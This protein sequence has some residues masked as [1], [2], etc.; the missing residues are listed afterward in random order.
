MVPRLRTHAP[1]MLLGGVAGLYADALATNPVLTQSLTAAATFALS[2]QIA[3]AYDR[4][5][6]RDALRTI[7]SALIGLLY[8]GPALFHYLNFVSRL[9]PGTGLQSVLLKTLFGQLGFGPALSCVFFAAFLVKEDGVAR[10]LAQL[11]QKIKQ[12]LVMTW[13][14]ELCFW[15]FVD[16]LCYSFVPMAWIPLGYNVANFLWTIFLSLQAAKTIES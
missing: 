6:P 10:G 11:P 8:F 2:D 16:L 3:Q 13:A 1:S 4:S 12:D 15:P 5:A 9:F 14:S 7:V